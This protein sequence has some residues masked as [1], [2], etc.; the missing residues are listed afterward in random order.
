MLILVPV[1]LGQTS[2]SVVICHTGQHF[3]A[4]WTGEMQQKSQVLRLIR[5]TDCF[6]LTLQPWL[7]LALLDDDARSDSL[8]SNPRVDV[9]LKVTSICL[10]M[11]S[12]V[13]LFHANNINLLA[14]D[15]LSLIR[16]DLPKCLELRLIAELTA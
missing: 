1:S 3:I 15:T 4:L 14:C 7:Y 9:A 11:V 8:A 16:I 2:S 6:E 13:L 10:Q 12:L 5:V